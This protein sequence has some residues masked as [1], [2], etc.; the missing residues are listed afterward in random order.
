MSFFEGILYVFERTWF[1]LSGAFMF[2]F[3]W[4]F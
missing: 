4:L 1:Y 2:F 3:G